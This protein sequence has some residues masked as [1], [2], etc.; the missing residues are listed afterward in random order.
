MY[1]IDPGK[2]QYKANLH[3]HS[4]LSDGR[5]T[6]QQ[7]KDVYEGQGYQILSIT[8]HE[9]PKDHSAMTT[10]EFLMLTGYEAYVRPDSNA[11]YDT[12]GPEIHLNLFS[13]DPHSEAY[14]CF[15]SCYC[16]FLNAEQKESLHKVGS[17]RP[18][19]YTVEYINEFIRTAKKNG[20][21]VS[22]NHPVWSMETE[23]RIFAYEGCFS[24]E[25][26]NYAG[27]TEN[28]MEYNGV[29]YDKLLRAGKRMF[30]HSGDDNHN[31]YPL[32]SPYSDSFGGFTMILADE[33][34]YDSVIQAME[35][36]D[37][38]SSMGPVFKEVSFDGETI[39]VECSEVVTVYCYFG[40]KTP[41]CLRANL[42]ETFTSAD[43]KIPRNAHYVRVSIMDSQGRYADTRGFFRDELGLE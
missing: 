39:H 16:K 19:E 13:K 21:L 23:E 6:P 22:Y 35:K 8:D 34:N 31:A 10:P 26:V 27:F 18:R 15:N 33:L 5:M 32:D 36:G 11:I 29:L 41:S 1:L 37:M 30:I 4:T 20:Y 28:N 17:Q 7:L 3:S 24:M 2:Q 12:Y 40:G 43:L 38:Y 14:V 25:M 42:G 9:V